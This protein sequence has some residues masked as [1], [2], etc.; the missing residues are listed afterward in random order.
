[1]PVAT[2]AEEIGEHDTKL[3]R[4]LNYYVEEGKQSRD[5]SDVGDVGVD[6]YRHKGYEFITVFLSHPAEKETKARI[7]DIE[8]NK[9]KGNASA[10]AEKFALFNGNKEQIKEITSDMCHGYRNAMKN[11]GH[12]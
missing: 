10:F 2:V 11:K 12:C 6:E 7:L 5:F 9:G 8:D 4:V 3:W 1:M